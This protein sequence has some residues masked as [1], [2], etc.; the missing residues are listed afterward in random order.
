MIELLYDSEY[1]NHHHKISSGHNVQCKDFV[2][3]KDSHCHQH[4]ESHITQSQRTN[5]RLSHDRTKGIAAY[6]GAVIY[7]PDTA[8]LENS[9]CYHK[10]CTSLVSYPSSMCVYSIWHLTAIERRALALVHQVYSDQVNT[11]VTI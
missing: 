1:F 4:S 2:V 7:T 8:C 11:G 3:S 10:A 9:M 5:R 6:L